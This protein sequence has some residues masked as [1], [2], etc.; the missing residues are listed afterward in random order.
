[1]A[2]KKGDMAGFRLQLQR[3]ATQVPQATSDE[4][5]EIAYEARNR[6]RD[7]A[8]IDYGDLKNAIGVKRFGVQ[9]PGGRFISGQSIYEVMIDMRKPVTAS[10]KLA[11]GIKTVGDYAWEVHEHMGWAGN[12]RPL[13]PSAKSVA[14]GRAAG[15]NAGGKFL[16]RALLDVDLKSGGIAERL[17]RRAKRTLRNLDK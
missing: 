11:E 17:A 7:M 16:S 10:D 1:M 2:F 9:G 13:M 4:L 15:V 5:R 8:P 6:A 12:W 14:A 3:A